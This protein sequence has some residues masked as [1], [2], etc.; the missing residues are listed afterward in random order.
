MPF[1]KATL[2][3]ETADGRHMTLLEPLVYVTAAGETITVPAGAETDGA[4]IP[5]WLWDAAPPFGAYWLACVLHDW[6][7]RQTH[8][9]REECDALLLEAMVSLGVPSVIREAI[10]RAVRLGGAGACEKDRGEKCE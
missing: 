1:L 8:R 6:L 5:R 9:A 7:Y 2:Q 3:V 10:Y 4:S